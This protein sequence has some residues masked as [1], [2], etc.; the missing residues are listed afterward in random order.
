MGLTSQLQA[1]FSSG[2]LGTN[3]ANYGGAGPTAAGITIIGTAAAA[4]IVSGGLYQLNIGALTSGP[5]YV[6]ATIN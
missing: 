6:W 5:F 4:P 1:D 2:G 3:L